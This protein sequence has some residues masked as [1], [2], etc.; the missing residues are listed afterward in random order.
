MTLVK[1]QYNGRE[2]PVF[3]N[4]DEATEYFARRRKTI[5]KGISALLLVFSVI[6]GIIVALFQPSLF[7]ALLSVILLAVGGLYCII[8]E[9]KI[10]APK[11]FMVFYS[12]EEGKWLLFPVNKYPAVAFVRENEDDTTE[13]DYTIDDRLVGVSEEDLKKNAVVVRIFAAS[14]FL[15]VI[16]MLIAPVLSIASVVGAAIVC[17]VILCW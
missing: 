13:E 2:L 12:K 15:A 6:L 10:R 16:L 1:K 4:M 3:D 5:Y 9:P 17:M 8:D 7:R 14:I 11:Q